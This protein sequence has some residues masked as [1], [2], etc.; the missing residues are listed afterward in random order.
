MPVTQ[1]WMHPRGSKRIH[2]C[3]NGETLCN[4]WGIPYAF[5]R[6][7]FGPF[8]PHLFRGKVCVDC[9]RRHGQL[10]R[11]FQLPVEPPEPI[12]SFGR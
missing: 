6:V 11:N 10:V 12:P 5:Y 9:L 4:R 1:G 7:G 3:L 2:Y 8:P